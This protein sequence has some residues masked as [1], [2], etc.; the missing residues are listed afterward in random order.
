MSDTTQDRLTKPFPAEMLRSVQKGGT[1]LTYVPIAEVIARLN[2]VLGNGWSYEV[3]DRWA[4]GEKET[5]TGTYPLMCMA[6]VRLTMTVNDATA[7]RDGIGG[8]AVKFLKDGT[9]P[10]DLGDEWKGA[11]SDALKKAA[12]HFGVGLELARKED[13]LKAEAEEHRQ[14]DYASAAKAGGWES[15]VEHD[16]HFHQLRERARALD[17]DAKALLR[18]WWDEQE[19]TMPLTREQHDTYAAQITEHE[20]HAQRPFDET[21]VA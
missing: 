12:Q 4:T 14:T 3:L 8:Q 1:N 20:A 7:T 10:V 21:R 13:A 2:D 15:F 19:F 17:D 9:A 11:V 18:K 6:H 16:E 5:D